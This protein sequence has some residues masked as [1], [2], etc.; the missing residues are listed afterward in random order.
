MKI[1]GDMQIE[2]KGVTSGPQKIKKVEKKGEDLSSGTVV[3]TVKQSDKVQISNRGKEIA[4]LI[5]VT[6]NMPET[7]DDKINSIKNSI[8]SGT[9]SVDPQKLAARILREL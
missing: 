3:Q 5:A 8:K 2:P 1:Y 7:R 6:K 9:Y 4:D